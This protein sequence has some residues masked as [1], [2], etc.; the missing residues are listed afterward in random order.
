MIFFNTRY[1]IF[2]FL[3]Q[4]K[5]YHILLFPAIVID[6]KKKKIY[7]VYGK[8]NLSI[9]KNVDNTYILQGV[10]SIIGYRAPPGC[11]FFIS[12]DYSYLYRQE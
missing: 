10:L 1:H 9:L 3:L 11:S 2:T 8:R 7:N 4:W 6:N 12:N 5:L